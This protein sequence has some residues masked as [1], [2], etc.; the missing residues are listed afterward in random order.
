MTPG[1]ANMVFEVTLSSINDTT[2]EYYNI[3]V[4]DRARRNPC[5]LILQYITF[6]VY[7]AKYKWKCEIVNTK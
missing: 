2:P 1:I 3:Q 6:G 5:E 7:R 4:I